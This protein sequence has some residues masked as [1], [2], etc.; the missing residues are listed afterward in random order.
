MD[1]FLGSTEFE[2]AEPTIAEIRLALAGQAG[3]SVRI[4]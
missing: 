1:G 3:R 2:M 4:R